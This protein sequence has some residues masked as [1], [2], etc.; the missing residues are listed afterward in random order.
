MDILN[1]NTFFF[2]MLDFLLVRENFYSVGFTHLL[3]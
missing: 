3:K 1:A 2:L